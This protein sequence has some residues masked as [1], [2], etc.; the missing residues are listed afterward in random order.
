MQKVVQKLIYYM[1]IVWGLDVEIYAAD[2]IGIMYYRMNKS[3][4]LLDFTL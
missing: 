2:Y 3:L 1:E 4:I